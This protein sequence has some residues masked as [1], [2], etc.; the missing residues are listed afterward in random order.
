MWWK[1]LPGSPEAAMPAPEGNR[2][3]G[4]HVALLRAVNAGGLNT[5][6]T[7]DFVRVL[8]GLGLADVRTYI[9]TG[10]AVFRAD[11]N[12]APTLAARIR[13]AIEVERGFAPETVVLSADELAAALA[14]NPFPEAAAEPKSL[15]LSFLAA[16]PAAPDLDRLAWL[17]GDGERYALAGR[18]FYL[19]AP[20]GVGR[21]KL[22]AQIERALGVAATA[23][24]WRTACALLE[25]A[26]ALAAE[27]PG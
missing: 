6:T 11:A 22:F 19:H 8:D 25:R 1:A 27:A 21:S 24:N 14:A 7:R 4:V 16:P 18:V 15:H 20:A 12:A 13:D 10:N 17:R 5:L 26:Q 23:R 2:L 3:A 9:Q